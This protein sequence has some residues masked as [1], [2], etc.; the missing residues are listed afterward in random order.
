MGSNIAK[1]IKDSQDLMV[2]SGRILN[3]EGQPIEGA[4]LDVWHADNEGHYDIQV[5]TGDET[6]YRG[7]FVTGK[8]GAYSF[9]SIKMKFYPIPNDG[10]VGKLLDAIGHHPYRPAHLHYLISAVGYEPL[11]THIFPSDDP[12]IDN[13]V[14]FGVKKDLVKEFEFHEGA[15]HG[16]SGSHWTVTHDFTL[17]SSQATATGFDPL[18]FVPKGSASNFKKK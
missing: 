3:T 6:N 7:K 5:E 11:T 2:V 4:V 17:A 8:D 13:D 16:C 10:P 14:V 15:G 1:K 9:V 12:Y 18:T